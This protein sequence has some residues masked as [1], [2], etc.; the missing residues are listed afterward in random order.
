[1]KTV[2]TQRFVLYSPNSIGRNVQQSIVRFFS[3]CPPL[4]PFMFGIPYQTSAPIVEPDQPVSVPVTPTGK[5]LSQVLKEPSLQNKVYPTKVQTNTPTKE[6][7]MHD[8]DLV[9]QLQAGQKEAFTLLVTKW[10]HPIFTFCLRQLGEQS[11]AEEATQD[12]FM[13]VF[14]GIHSFRLDSKFSTWL[15]RIATNHCINLRA[16]HHRRQRHMHTSIEDLENSLSEPSE[17]SKKLEQADFES[18]LQAALGQVPEEHRALLILRDI[19]DCSYE[20]IAAISGLN[21]GT[22]KSRIHRGRK[23]LRTILEGGNDE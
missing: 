16:K 13:K 17:Q 19:Q 3:A 7:H 14:S 18:R 11:L 9:Q 2:P 8:E 6:A 20:E 4:Q 21:L 10:Q 1:M 15:Y 22:I 23:Q 12:V 5:A